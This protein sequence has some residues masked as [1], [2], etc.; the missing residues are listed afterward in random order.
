MYHVRAI[1]QHL[2]NEGALIIFPAGEV[3]RMGATGVRDGLWLP[4]FLRFAS[5]ARAPIVPLFVDARNS[6]FFYSLSMLAKPLSTLWLVREMFKHNNKNMRIRIGQAIGCEVYDALPL[7][8]RGKT[9]VFRRHVYKI[10]KNGAQKVHGIWTLGV[11]CG[12][13][14]VNR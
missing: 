3:S 8:G 12:S 4:G 1:D 11:A 14:T 6:V 9:K 2:K 7:D 10:G 13:Y 5:K